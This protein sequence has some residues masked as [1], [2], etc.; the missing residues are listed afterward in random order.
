MQ[1]TH[2]LA[3][4]PDDELLRRLVDLLRHSRHAE[5]DLVAHVGEVDARRL[6]AREA[7]PS[8][9][10]YCTQ[11]LH[12]SDAEAYL[13]IAAARASRE[14]PV[15]LEMLADGRLHLTAIAKLAPHLTAENREALLARAVHKSKRQ[16]EELVAKIAPRPDV[17]ASMRRLPACRLVAAA[18]SAVRVDPDGVT[19][20]APPAPRGLDLTAA[21]LELRPERV[22]LDGS[23]GM[24]APEVA[25]RAGAE[26]APGPVQLPDA[27]AEPHFQ[28]RWVGDRTPRPA[29]VEPLAPGRY[30]VQF[31]SSAELH[32][33]LER[34]RG[35]MRS[36]VP[37]GD[38]AA[39]IEQAVTE[40]LERLEARR[41]GRTRAPRTVVPAR[42]SASASG[43]EPSAAAGEGC[44]SS[45]ADSAATA[46]GSTVPAPAST[47][48]RSPVAGSPSASV[49]PS[50]S[51]HVPAAVRRAVYERDGGRCRYVDE[52]GRRCTARDGLEFHHRHPFGH[53]GGHSAED[54]SLACHGHNMYLAEVDYGREAMARHRRSRSGSRSPCP[55]T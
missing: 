52:Q 9:F 18:A 4:I 37:D 11:R 24:A 36:S 33:K 7:S 40:K 20:L 25:P 23:G 21:P 6:Y 17:P 42:D 32:D 8:M 39:I 16:V 19:P 55:R 43:G 26:A 53:G 30:R 10:A 5:A 15:L 35:L 46:G 22:A 49:R 2:D 44:T 48:E 12:L 28:L 14:H 38:L 31:T 13:R 3:T 34:L 45:S 54:V 1:S 47:G 29:V 27:D 41:F 51:R 50:A